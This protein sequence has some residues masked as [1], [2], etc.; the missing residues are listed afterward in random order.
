MSI[1]C[2]SVS[3]LL[4]GVNVPDH[5]MTFQSL[6][7]LL[8]LSVTPYVVSLQ[9]KECGGWYVQYK[10][11]TNTCSLHQLL[12]HCQQVIWFPV[13]I[14]LNSLFLVV[15]PLHLSALKHLMQKVLKRLMGSCL[16]VDEE[17]DTE[18]CSTQSNQK[19]V[20][21]SLSTLC[22]WY[23]SKVWRR[24]LPAECWIVATNDFWVIL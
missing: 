12:M 18:Q 8:Q 9:A 11:S 7:E 19:R 3:S 4:P 1:L 23:K 13:G 10:G 16:S 15:A 17:E 14:A 2:V 22:D 21:C 24:Q 5:D 6:T 20:H